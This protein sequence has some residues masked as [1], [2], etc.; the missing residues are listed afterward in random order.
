MF[1]GT[2]ATMLRVLQQLSHDHRTLALL[3]FMPTLLLVL[4]RFVFDKQDMVFNA[5]GPS[6]IA[7]FPFTTMFLVTSIATQRERSDG[8]LER[9]MNM[10]LGK[11]GYLLGYALA[12]SLMAVVQAA[13][14]T[15]VSFNWLG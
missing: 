11:A 1:R 9:L 7:I 5:I 10:P 13:I 15:F 3:W 8:T 12:F 2:F 4:L 6:L 14:V